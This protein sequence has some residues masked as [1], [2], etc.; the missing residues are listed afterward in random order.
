MGLFRW[1][2]SVKY[3]GF[4][5]IQSS[6]CRAFNACD[7]STF[8]TKQLPDVWQMIKILQARI[9]SLWPDSAPILRW[10]GLS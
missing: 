4:S 1:S 8:Y 3:P 5:V 6:R 10:P 7:L 2:K 9:N